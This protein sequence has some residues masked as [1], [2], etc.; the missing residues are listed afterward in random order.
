[1]E[2]TT[3]ADH[4]IKKKEN[5]T[6]IEYLDFARKLGKIIEDAVIPIGIVALWTMSKS[7]IN[8]LEL[9]EMKASWI[10]HQ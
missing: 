1:M 8:G 10:E 3:P 9:L 6:W 5:E 7:L 2:F 4:R